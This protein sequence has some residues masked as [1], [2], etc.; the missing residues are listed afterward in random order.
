[1][2]VRVV[3]DLG[4][5]PFAV[6][7]SVCAAF[8]ARSSRGRQRIAW[9]CF[10]IGVGGWA[11]GSALWAY[12]EL[13]TDAAP[14]PSV[15]DAGYLLFPIAACVGMVLF[16]IGYSSQSRTR[17]VLDGLIVAGGCS[18]WPGCSSCAVSGKR[19][20]RAGSPSDCRWHI[21]PQTLSSSRSPC[22][23]WRGPPPD[24]G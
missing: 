24:S 3:D 12:Y 15:A 1:M 5:V 22:S 10:S 23:C 2:T 16:P 9:A 21:P 6:F 19:A 4:L 17:L 14:F 8:A 13:L 11:V 7:G 18:K 20:A